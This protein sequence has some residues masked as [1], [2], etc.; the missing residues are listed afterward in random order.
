MT[1][2]MFYWE[3]RCKEN[4]FNLKKLLICYLLVRYIIS[5]Y[6]LITILFPEVHYLHGINDIGKA[7]YILISICILIDLLTLP[8]NSI[9]AKFATNNYLNNY[10]FKND[11]NGNSPVDDN[12][13]IDSDN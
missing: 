3:I 4:I 13:K 9:V 8:K 7:K 10:E 5:I 2:K 12:V 1:L 11:I 6:S